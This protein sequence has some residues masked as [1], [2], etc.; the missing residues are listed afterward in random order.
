MG[1]GAYLLCGRCT[2]DIMDFELQPKMHQNTKMLA[3]TF[4]RRGQ[5]VDVRYKEVHEKKHGLKF[6][7]FDEMFI[8]PG[9][10]D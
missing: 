6:I 2:S 4:F 3:E 8:R 1:Q 7:T 10:N 9:G 5:G